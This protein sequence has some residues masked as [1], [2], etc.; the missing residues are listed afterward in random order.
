MLGEIAAAF[1]GLPEYIMT[2]AS[3]HHTM[4]K[5]S[6]G[7]APDISD[8]IRLANQ[9]TH[10]VQLTPNR[11]DEPLLKSAFKAV[12]LD[13]RAGEALADQLIPLKQSA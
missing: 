7:E 1:W 8:I 5:K 10:W 9:L 13:E 6:P 2:C 11:I 3:N 12:G 4:T